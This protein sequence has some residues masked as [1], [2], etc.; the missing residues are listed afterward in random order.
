MNL[1]KYNFKGG[2]VELDPRIQ[3]LLQNDKQLFFQKVFPMYLPSSCTTLSL[4]PNPPGRAGSPTPSTPT[5]LPIPTDYSTASSQVG[6]PIITS[7]LPWGNREI[8]IWVLNQK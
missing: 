8:H 4:Q 2:V 6:T 7:K 3:K 5:P 1:L